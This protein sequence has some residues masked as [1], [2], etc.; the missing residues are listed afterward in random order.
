EILELLANLGRDARHSDDVRV[1]HKYFGWQCCDPQLFRLCSEW[2]R[3]Q[4][5]LE[6]VEAFFGEWWCSEGFLQQIAEL[7]ER[8]IHGCGKCLELDALVARR[9]HRE[10]EC[11]GS[12]LVRV[13][14]E[15]EVEGSGFAEVDGKRTLL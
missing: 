8:L 15:E 4:R 6:P 7:V 2:C 3:R 12:G 9:D 13:V 11:A 1:T 5:E 14:E 10:G